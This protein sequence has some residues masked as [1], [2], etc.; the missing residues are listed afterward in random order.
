[1]LTVPR[2]SVSEHCDIFEKT[3]KAWFSFGVSI[4]LTILV[5]ARHFMICSMGCL[6]PLLSCW[7]LVSLHQVNSR[8]SRHQAAE[9]Q[10][11]V[12][13]IGGISHCSGHRDNAYLIQEQESHILEEISVGNSAESRHF[14]HKQL[15]R[16]INQ[17]S[18]NLEGMS[19][20]TLSFPVAC[21]L[22]S[23]HP[24]CFMKQLLCSCTR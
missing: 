9:F 13:N 20:F 6:Q 5:Q 21:F 2:S 10:S 4:V 12:Q 14:I 19:E 18:A 7:M 11:T 15:W 8:L 24:T 23:A 1:M 3:K 17:M 22:V 16:I